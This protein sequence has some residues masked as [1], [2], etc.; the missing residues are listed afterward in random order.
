MGG[1]SQAV[2]DEFALPPR[3][4]A[5]RPEDC[6]GSGC[7]NCIYAVYENALTTWEREVERIVARAHRSGQANPSLEK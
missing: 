3:P 5:P 6:C 1:D 7:A 2:S 4:E